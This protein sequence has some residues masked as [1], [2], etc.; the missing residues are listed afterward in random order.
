MKILHLILNKYIFFCNFMSYI[1]VSLFTC[2]MSYSWLFAVI[3]YH[4]YLLYHSITKGL[5]LQCV[6]MD[7]TKLQD[8][9]S[10]SSS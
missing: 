5:S 9:K 6:N 1:N 2:E 8:V 7:G 10:T 4:F 3:H